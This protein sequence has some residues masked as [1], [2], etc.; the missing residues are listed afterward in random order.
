GH[1]N[2]RSHEH[3][4]VRPL[5]TGNYREVLV[6]LERIH[7]TFTNVR[8]LGGAGNL[9]EA[10]P[11]QSDIDVDTSLRPEFAQP[12]QF[13]ISAGRK[14]PPVLDLRPDHG[15][16]GDNQQEETNRF[17]YSNVILFHFANTHSLALL[18]AASADDY[19]CVPHVPEESISDVYHFG[20]ASTAALSLQFHVEFEHRNGS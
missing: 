1:R 7:N 13:G 19:E 10:R 15:T 11:V 4:K 3:R 20:I 17:E 12:A 14:R 8:L 16:P 5:R 6:R 9:A 2:C 18:K